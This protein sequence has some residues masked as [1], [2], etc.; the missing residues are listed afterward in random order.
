MPCLKVWE[1]LDIIASR[2]SGI[3]YL[4]ESDRLRSFIERISIFTSDQLNPRQ[5]A[6]Q[7]PLDTREY[8]VHLDTGIREAIGHYIERYECRPFTYECSY[9]LQIGYEET[10]LGIT[11]ST[12]TFLQKS[13]FNIDPASF[14]FVLDDCY[15]TE[16]AGQIKA[17]ER[18]ASIDELGSL[19]LWPEFMW[20]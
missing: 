18:Y 20:A 13:Q 15:D 10:R 19:S 3:D 1:R 5:N 14:C 9:F 8:C 12:L 2:P 11:K 6:G 7:L 17:L 16:K 4:R